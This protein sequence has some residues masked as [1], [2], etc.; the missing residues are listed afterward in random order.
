MAR[1][2]FSKEAQEYLGLARERN[3][4]LAHAK[5]EYRIYLAKYPEGEDAQRVR[6]RLDALVTAYQ[7]PMPG[8]PQFAGFQKVKQWQFLWSFIAIL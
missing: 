7:A 2:V 3:G 4:Q 1:T 8:L 5:A 6:Q